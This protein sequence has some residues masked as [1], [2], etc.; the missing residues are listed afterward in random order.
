MSLALGDPIPAFELPDTEGTP[1]AVPVEPAP[2]ATVVVVTC[3]HCPYVIAWDPRPW[4]LGQVAGVIGRS[5]GRRLHEP[6][7]APRNA[8]STFSPYTS[9]A[10]WGSAPEMFMQTT[11]V[12]P[13]FSISRMRSA[14]TSGSEERMKASL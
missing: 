4:V 3:N 8:G 2:P 7:R 11:T 6:T 12:A 13:S 5:W 14:C 9:M 10:L 1:H